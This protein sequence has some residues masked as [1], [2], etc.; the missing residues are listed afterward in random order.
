MRSSVTSR[1]T[2]K[3][4]RAW[5]APR[6]APWVGATTSSAEDRRL[7]EPALLYVCYHRHVPRIDALIERQARQGGPPLTVAFADEVI[8]ELVQ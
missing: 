6:V 3:R 2:P 5:S 4:S 7:L 1:R 8:G